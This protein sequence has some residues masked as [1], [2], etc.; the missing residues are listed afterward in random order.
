MERSRPA[1]H[2]RAAIASPCRLYPVLRTGGLSR[3]ARAESTL[4]SLP[5]LPRWCRLAT[6]C[7]TLGFGA[8]ALAQAGEEAT[9]WGSVVLP[10]GR[11]V[12]VELALDEATRARGLMER[13]HLAPDRG[14]LFV[15]ER[16]DHHAFWMKRC[17]IALDIVW[18]DASGT[19]VDVAHEA[20]PCPEEG[21]C[22]TL[23]PLR[24]ARYVLEVAAGTARREGLELGAQLEL[25]LPRELRP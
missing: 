10:S 7:V 22:P 20:A 8:S 12:F 2:A 16:A 14:M 9:R 25:R 18:L 6:L 1:R 4:D 13:E 23:V 15:F 17:R 24:R 11:E 3:V 19:V 21:P 5:H